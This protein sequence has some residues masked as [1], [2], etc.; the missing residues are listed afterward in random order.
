MN[1]RAFVKRTGGA[2]A[3]AALSPCLIAAVSATAKRELKK[4]IMWGTVGLKG[5]VLE[6][7]KAVK[8]AGF[9]GAEMNSHMIQD[10][11]LRGRD[12]TGLVIP[13]VCGVHHWKKPLSDPDPKIRE[14]GLE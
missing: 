4:A 7:M 5:S 9:A 13:S 2:L 11:V 8:E 12:E 6:N 10:E 14:E 1:R 3:L